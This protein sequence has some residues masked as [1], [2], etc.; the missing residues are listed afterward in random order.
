MY[1][2][3]LFFVALIFCVYAETLCK[4]NIVSVLSII[5]KLQVLKNAIFLNVKKTFQK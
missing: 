1:R 2:E 4:Q 5:K 3:F